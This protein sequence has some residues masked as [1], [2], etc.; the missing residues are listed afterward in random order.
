M[1][2]RDVRRAHRLE[3]IPVDPVILANRLGIKVYNAKFADD[4]LVGMIA[5]RGGNLH[6][7]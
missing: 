6:C 7:S 5:K 1:K 4:N 3:T 2:A